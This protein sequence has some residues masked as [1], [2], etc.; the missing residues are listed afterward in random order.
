MTAPD[1]T[2][3]L[4]SAILHVRKQQ[5]MSSHAFATEKSRAS[6]SFIKL[7]VPKKFTNQGYIATI[8]RTYTDTSFINGDIP[9]KLAL[10]FVKSAKA[11]GL[12]TNSPHNFEVFGLSSLV[13][14]SNKIPLYNLSFN[15][16]Y[17][18]LY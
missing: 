13:C 16:S 6:G 4:N 3:S 1:V 9:S 15:K 18:T 11:V 7:N 8:T 14:K 10:G 17:W 5:V 12:W 2:V